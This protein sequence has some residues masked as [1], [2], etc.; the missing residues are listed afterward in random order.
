MALF[1][2][3]IQ[4]LPQRLGGSGVGGPTLCLP[5]ISSALLRPGSMGRNTTLRGIDERMPCLQ[6]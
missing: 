6:G 1:A 3:H 2:G 4:N 5:K